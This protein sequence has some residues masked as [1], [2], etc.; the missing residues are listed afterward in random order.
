MLFPVHIV[1]V[2]WKN[3]KSSSDFCQENYFALKNKTQFNIE[4]KLEIA[5]RTEEPV[6]NSTPTE[7]KNLYP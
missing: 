1:H 4:V 3:I 2:T 7:W 6:V 5:S